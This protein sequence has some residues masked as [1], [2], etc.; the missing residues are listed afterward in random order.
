M[1]TPTDQLE[2]P[3][4]S[5]LDAA[6]LAPNTDLERVQKLCAAAVAYTRARDALLKKSAPPA[7]A[8]TAANPRNSAGRM[9]VPFGRR[10]GDYLDDCTDAELL[11]LRDAIDES[12]SEPEKARFKAKN[13]ALRD[14]ITAVLRGRGAA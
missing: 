3:R 7:P 6:G 12:I 4:R 1:D 5:L 2:A 9:L 8:P 11:W 10:Q 14:G 13:L